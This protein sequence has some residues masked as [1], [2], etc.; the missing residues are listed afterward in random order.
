VSYHRFCEDFVGVL[1]VNKSFAVGFL[2]SRKSLVA[3]VLLF[4]GFECLF[5]FVF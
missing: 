3:L 2:V 1:C 5:V 4:L